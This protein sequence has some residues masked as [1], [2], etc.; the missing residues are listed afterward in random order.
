MNLL[1]ITGPSPRV[2]N[3]DNLLY[4]EKSGYDK[5]V[6]TLWF[7]GGRSID[8]KASMEEVSKAIGNQ[9]KDNMYSLREAG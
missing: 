4:T 1:I 3:L 8:I 7:V 5:E 6:T 9:D 2:I